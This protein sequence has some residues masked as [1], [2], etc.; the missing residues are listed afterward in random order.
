MHFF[1]SKSSAA[2]RDTT[3]AADKT[4]KA[5]EQVGATEV[6]QFTD[7]RA[8]VFRFTDNRPQSHAQIRFFR[9]WP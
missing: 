6:F 7:N 3:V 5:P 8:G 4:G 2:Q 9:A 1:T